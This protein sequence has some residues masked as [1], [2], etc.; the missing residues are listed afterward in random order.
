MVKCLLNLLPIFK[1]VF[2]TTYYWVIRV[3]YISRNMF[4]N[5]FSP[6]LWLVI[7][8]T[9]EC[10][11]EDKCLK[12]FYE[13][14]CIIITLMFCAFCIPSKKSLPRRSFIALALTFTSMIHCKFI[15]FLV[16]GEFQCSFPLP[17]DIQLLQHHLLKSLP[18]P[19][20]LPW[21]FCWKSIDQTTLG[22]F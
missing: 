10:L 19:I 14:H 18:F 17:L 9:L 16:Q 5:F 1:W 13:V 15:L 6:T 3:H 7:S 2:L 22:Y 12:F 4:C 20:E 8:S 11:F 21:H